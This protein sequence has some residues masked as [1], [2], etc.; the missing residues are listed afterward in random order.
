MFIFKNVSLPVNKAVSTI[1]IPGTKTNK[2]SLFVHF[3]IYSHLR[4]CN[5]LVHLLDISAS[6]KKTL[7]FFVYSAAVAQSARC[8]KVKER[9]LGRASIFTH[10][11]N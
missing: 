5:S 1:A 8:R 7:V 10:Y 2:S 3:K 9:N 6:Y 11:F 4:T